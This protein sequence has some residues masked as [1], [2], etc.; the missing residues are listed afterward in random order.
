MARLKGGKR[1]KERGKKIEEGQRFGCRLG[2]GRVVQ[3]YISVLSFVTCRALSTRDEM[4]LE[5]E[6]VEGV[7][8][9]SVHYT[10]FW[11]LTAH[12]QNEHVFC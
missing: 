12:E 10:R 5:G 4:V 8:T 6:V 1:E 7:L 11:P 2:S 3:S 9:K